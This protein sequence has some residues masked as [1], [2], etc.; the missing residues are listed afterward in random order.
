MRT[1]IDGSGRLVVPAE[2]RRRMG[3][4]G[5]ESLELELR[6]GILEVRVAPTPVRLVEQRGGGVTAVPDRPLPPLT[7]AI[8]QDT[9]D[10]VRR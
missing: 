2:L 8:V 1:T 7:R 9:I 10:S 6:D 5:G 3:L 4:E